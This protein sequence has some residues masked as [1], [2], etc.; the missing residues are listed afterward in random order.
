MQLP[1]PQAL[2]YQ[3][4]ERLE[5]MLTYRFDGSPDVVYYEIL[6]IP[7]ERCE[8]I[9]ELKVDHYALMPQQALWLPIV[10]AESAPIVL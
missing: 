5:Q 8:D 7:L 6:N 1:K 9:K 4:A 2:Q 10:N 3:K